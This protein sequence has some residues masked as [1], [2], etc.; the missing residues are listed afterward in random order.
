MLFSDLLI[1]VIFQDKY[2]NDMTDAIWNQCK[3]TEGVLNMAIIFVALLNEKEL[4]VRKA[5]SFT[6]R[7]VFRTIRCFG[8]CE[9]IY[10]SHWLEIAN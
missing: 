9:F 6:L 3:Y 10:I 2:I 1:C 4:D 8:K 7:P 5:K